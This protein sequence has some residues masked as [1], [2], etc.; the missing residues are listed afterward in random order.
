MAQEPAVSLS[1]RVGKLTSLTDVQ[2]ELTRIYRAARRGELGTQDLTRLTYTLQVI[3]KVIEQ[4]D[5]E[6]RLAAIEQ[7]LSDADANHHHAPYSH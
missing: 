4:T 6:A 2:R 5:T 1:P 7:A 3:A